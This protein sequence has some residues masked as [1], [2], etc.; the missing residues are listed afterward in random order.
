MH[1]VLIRDDE[2]GQFRRISEDDAP[3]PKDPVMYR[4]VN[5][6]AHD[7]CLLWNGERLCSYPVPHE[8]DR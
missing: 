7:V 8:H 1:R 6:P 2:L 3:L 5:E 4:V